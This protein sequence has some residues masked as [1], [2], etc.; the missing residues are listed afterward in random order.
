MVSQTAGIYAGGLIIA[1]VKS[2]LM[3]LEIILS[4]RTIAQK[5]SLNIDAYR[6][7]QLSV[8]WDLLDF[9]SYCVLEMLS[10]LTG[11]V[12]CKRKWKAWSAKLSSLRRSSV[13][14]I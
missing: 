4:L 5:T 2:H 6:T 10:Q 8:S 9:Q 1:Q 7:V 12:F 14:D 3:W 11:L 13:Y